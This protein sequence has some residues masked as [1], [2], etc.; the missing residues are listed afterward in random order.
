MSVNYIYDSAGGPIR[1]ARLPPLSPS[2]DNG[3]SRACAEGKSCQDVK[4]IAL[5]KQDSL[6]LGILSGGYSL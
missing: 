5:A 6:E 4:T 3:S 1:P 2:N